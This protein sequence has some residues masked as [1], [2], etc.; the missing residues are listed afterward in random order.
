MRGPNVD[1]FIVIISSPLLAVRGAGQLT[2]LYRPS[3]RYTT[4]ICIINFTEMHSQLDIIVY[5]LSTYS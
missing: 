2:R 5:R 3:H 1:M 4:R